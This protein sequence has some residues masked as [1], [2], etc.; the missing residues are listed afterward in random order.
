MTCNVEH[1][2]T[3]LFVI[4]IS[5]LAR[6]LLRS[7][8][9]FIIG[10]YIFVLLSFKDTLWIGYQFFSRCAFANIFSQSVVCHNSLDIVLCR[11]EVFILMKS[12][13]LFLLW[14]MRLVLYLKS[15]CHTQHQLNFLPLSSR[16]SRVSDFTFRS[17]IHF[18]LI[19]VKG[20]RSMSRF[21]FP[22][23]CPVVPISSV[24]KTIFSPQYCL[25]SCVK[26]R[27]T[28]FMWLYFGLLSGWSLVFVHSL[29][30]PQGGLGPKEGPSWLPL[31]VIVL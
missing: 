9:H 11:A 16:C 8:T 20:I 14:T 23:G 22:C 19:V 3:C 21:F 29:P 17:M 1:I 25:C 30:K 13:L 2:S 10:L 12:S 6:C 18:Q 7:L 24:V 15:H 28:I 26:E 31:S 5:S 4:F 27:P